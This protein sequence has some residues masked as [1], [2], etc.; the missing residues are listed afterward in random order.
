MFLIVIERLLTSKARVK[1]HPF[2]VNKECAIFL[3]LKQ[4]FR[5]QKELSKMVYGIL[6]SLIS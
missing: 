4:Y 6:I 1:I 5:R 3:D 2:Q